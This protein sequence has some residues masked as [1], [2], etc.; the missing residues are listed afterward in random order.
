MRGAPNDIHGTGGKK[1]TFRSTNQKIK[2]RTRK[3][4]FLALKPPKALIDIRP[5]NGLRLYCCPQSIVVAPIHVFLSDTNK[6]PL[7]SMK[8]SKYAQRTLYT[9]R[10][11]KK[12]KLP[13]IRIYARCIIFTMVISPYGVEFVKS[14]RFLPKKHGTHVN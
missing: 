6:A 2:C 3:Q 12:T 1:L 10:Q 9:L 13:R 11:L 7:Q 5:K 14:D 4:F 8:V